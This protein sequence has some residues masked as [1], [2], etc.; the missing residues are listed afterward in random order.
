MCRMNGFLVVGTIVLAGFV[1]LLVFLSYRANRS[2]PAIAS[3]SAS[4]DSHA[5]RPYLA[6]MYGNPPGWHCSQSALPGFPDVQKRV[7]DAVRADPILVPKTFYA[8]GE[9]LPLGYKCSGA[10]GLVYRTANENGSVVVEPLRA[11][12]SLVRC[13]GTVSSSHR[14]R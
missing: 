11:G 7:C 10:D 13:G 5:Y 1:G 14:Y 8:Y 6:T 4:P 12:S 3:V 9:A 2:I